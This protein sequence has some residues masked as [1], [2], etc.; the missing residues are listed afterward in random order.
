MLDAPTSIAAANRTERLLRLATGFVGV[1]LAVAAGYLAL[2]RLGGDARTL[3]YDLP[4]TISHHSYGGVD[5]VRIVYIDELDGSFVNRSAQSKLLDKLNEAGARAVV[6]DLIFDAPSQD[7]SI[8]REFAAAMLRFRGVD[9]NLTPIPGKTQRP[10]LLACGRRALNHAAASPEEVSVIGEQLI[11]PNDELLAAADDFG[12]VALMHDKKFTVRELSTG[13]PDEPSLT[14]KAAVALGAP[15]A[16]ADR[17]SPRWVN[18]AGRPNTIPTF[19][20]SRLLAGP[21]PTFLRDKVVVVGA[22]PG[23]AGAA[24]GVD[25][26]ST[27]YHRLDLRGDLDLM[28]GV[29]VQATLLANLLSNNWLTS[30]TAGSDT[31]LIKIAGLLAGILF[32]WLRP[33]RGFL[34]A[35]LMIAGLICAGT[36]SMNYHRF[37]FP[38]SVVAFLQIPVALVWGT[39]SHFYIERFFRAKL[40]EEQRQL[41]E[42]FAKYLS[43]QMLDRLTSEGFRMKVGGEKIEAA[44][45]FTDIEDFTNMSERVGDPEKIV[46][47]LNEYFERT[48]SHV[49]DDDGVVIKFIGDAIFAA[50]GA[51]LPEPQAAPKAARAAWKLSQSS[52]EVINGERLNTRIGLHF[53]EVVAGNIGSVRRV[54]YTMIGDAVNLAARLES[55]NKALGTSILMS[56]E[57]CRRL[58]NE[59]VTRKVGNFRVKG[60]REITVIHELLGPADSGIPPWIAFY[61]EALA[62]L[63]ADAPKH[64]CELFMKTSASKGETDGP[65]QFFMKRLDAGELI[66]GGVIEM[67]EK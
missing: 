12:L 22:K 59:F 34:L 57:V 55:L 51:P 47:T 30:S 64:A 46:S 44:I 37:W 43:P 27:P 32:S 39:A 26:F 8:D 18:Y 11:P 54:D 35:S 6:Y 56:D 61:H 4:F 67:T 13:T 2:F 16:E 33:A 5:D 25:L 48:T 20:A 31:W 66:S 40:T 24:A 63:E 28:S 62:A 9:E 41:R 17:E 38:W 36:L 60:R 1:A 52:R 21:L 7:P 42:A 19:D 49:F 23:M 50:W 45:L 29:E 58:G 14:W 3:S 10:I 15:L 53:G 65:S